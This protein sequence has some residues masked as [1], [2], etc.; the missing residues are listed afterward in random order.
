[1]SQGEKKKGRG[2]DVKRA[3]DGY[4]TAKQAQERLEMKP[5]TFRYYV[6]RGRI[7]RHVPPLKTEGYYLKEEID[8]LATELALYTHTATDEKQ[9]TKTRIAQPADAQG[10]V[11]VLLSFG[12]QTTTAQ[13]R[14]DWYKVN[15][16]VDYVALIDGIVGGYIHAVP[17]EPETLE[18]LMSGKKHSRQVRPSEILSYEP[19]KSYSL[20]IGIASRKDIA[21]H[22]QRVGF[23]LISGFFVFL[24]ELAARQIFIHRLYA[25]SDQPD[26]IELCRGLGFVQLPAQEGDKF[27]RW[28]LDLETSDSHFARLYRQAIQELK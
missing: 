6:L 14:I 25:V 26:G 5:S 27:P 4:Y 9:V 12:W 22:V 24:E 1:M 19:G 23:R 10:I 3:P 11:D 17:Y 2:G 28:M 7:Q 13:Q 15:P 21:H 20:Y 18:A 8:R 16:F